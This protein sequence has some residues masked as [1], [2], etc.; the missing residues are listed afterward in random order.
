MGTC[1]MGIIRHYW[2]RIKC[3]IGIHEYNV[4]EPNIVKKS[5]IEPAT[6]FNYYTGKFEQDMPKKICI[7]FLYAGYIV[8]CYNC[9]H[10]KI[11]PEFQVQDENLPILQPELDDD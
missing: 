3:V 8:S 7:G 1:F 2:K 4:A 6:T 9:S 11:M 5:Y 10:T